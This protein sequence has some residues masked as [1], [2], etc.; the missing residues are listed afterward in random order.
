[1][2]YIAADGQVR[3]S[4]VQNGRPR[5]LLRGEK[6]VY[7]AVFMDEPPVRDPANFDGPGLE[8]SRR[9]INYSK[10][11]FTTFMVST[12][13][14]GRLQGNNEPVRT[15]MDIDRPVKLRPISPD[16]THSL[17][18]GSARLE[19]GDNT[20]VQL[21]LSAAGKERLPGSLSRVYTT[22]NNAKPS[23]WELGLTIG[24]SFGPRIVGDDNT[25]QYVKEG[26][27]SN[28]YASS[29]LNILRPHLPRTHRSLGLVF[30]T[31]LTRGNIMDEL[32]AGVGI[33]RLVGDAGLV[34]G[35][36]WQEVKISQMNV[37]TGRSR[38]ESKRVPRF[39]VGFDLR[40]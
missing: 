5:H 10:E 27:Q 2:V 30:G 7:A 6:Y 9:S 19:V 18:F 20:D 35:A 33:G 22:L 29:Y 32:L 1:V 16:S 14:A 40:M 17:W 15:V 23:L 31:N 24:S 34:V 26:A 8:L 25:G 3:Q 11:A 13:G 39:F 12:F 28:I 37:E 4:V 21:S 38:T 36:V